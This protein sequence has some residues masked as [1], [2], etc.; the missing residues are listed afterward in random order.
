MHSCPMYSFLHKSKLLSS[1]DLRS[2]YYHVKFSPETR[3]ISAF[4]SIFGMYEFLNMQG[5][6]YFTALI[7]RVFGQFNDF[8]FFHMDNIFIHDS[9]EKDYLEHLRMPLLK[10]REQVLS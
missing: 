4:T 1:L 8:F 7:Q 2:G 9:K 5:Q 10:I 6:A 3:H